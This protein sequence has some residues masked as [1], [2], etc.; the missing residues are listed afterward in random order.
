SRMTVP[1]AMPCG[2]VVAD[3]ADKCSTT[4]TAR[5]EPVDEEGS[6]SRRL[7]QAS[8]EHRHLEG[9]L[10]AFELWRLQDHDG[11]LNSIALRAEHRYR[12]VRRILGKTLA[13]LIPFL[14]EILGQH[15]PCRSNRT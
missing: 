3:A 12:G 6:G 4:I 11:I 1:G 9:Q 14:E 2:A 5:G 10:V 15:V 8:F 7:G 13:S